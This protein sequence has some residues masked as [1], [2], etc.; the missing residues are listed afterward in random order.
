MKKNPQ[1]FLR[2]ESSNELPF[3]RFWE[4]MRCSIHDF[5]NVQLLDFHIVTPQIPSRKAPEVFLVWF[6]I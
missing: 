3:Q 6:P 1:L 4:T 2:Y 5:W